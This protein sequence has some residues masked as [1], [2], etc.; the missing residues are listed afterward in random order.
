MFAFRQI[1]KIANRLPSLI[2]VC[3]CQI[4]TCTVLFIYNNLDFPG[5]C[6]F[7]G[8]NRDAAACK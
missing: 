4:N 6:F 1:S 5:A 2:L 7:W 3:G 8:D